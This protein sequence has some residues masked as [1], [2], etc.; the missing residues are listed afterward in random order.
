MNATQ[1]IQGECSKCLGSGRVPF[2][3]IEN[4]VCFQCGGTGKISGRI[5][6]GK[7]PK[8]IEPTISDAEALK[9]IATIL[10][11]MKETGGYKAFMHTDAEMYVIG[12]RLASIMAV[13]ESAE[14]FRK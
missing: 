12:P 2:R 1:T 7:T 14:S 5:K 6:T 8:A 4:G 3:H 10:D 9:R 11:V 13:L